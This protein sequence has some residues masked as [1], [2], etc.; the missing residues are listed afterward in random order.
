MALKATTYKAELDV[1]DMDR[2]YYGTQVQ[3]ALEILERA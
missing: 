3:I 1:S 2:Q